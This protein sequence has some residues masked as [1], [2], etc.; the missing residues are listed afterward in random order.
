M[1]AAAGWFP[2]DDGQQRYWDGEQWTEHFAPGVEP[3]TEVKG[4]NGTIILDADFLTIRRTGFLAR[5][6][7]GKG[8]KRIPIA[9]ITAIQ[10]KPAAAVMNG[11]IQFTLGGGNEGR[12]RFG[13]QTAD[14]AKD[15]N[16]V[17]F[18]KRQMPRF[19]Q[20]RDEI[21]GVIAERGRPASY[22]AP[23]DPMAQLK[24]LAEL[25][26]AGVVTEDEFAV[27]KASILAQ[28]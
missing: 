1:N 6:S 26:D 4:H 10:W 7:I 18:V 23:A 13:H 21:E 16:T 22:P 2:Q 25:R 17:I 15:E 5:A 11:F 3:A 12:S 9:S 8:E 20:L 28:V 19:Q 14:A 24:Q 27:K